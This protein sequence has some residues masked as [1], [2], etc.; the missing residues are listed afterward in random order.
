VA[1]RALEAR[2]QGQLRQIGDADAQLL[3]DRLAAATAVTA[4]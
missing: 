1:A 2:L 3:C 4:A